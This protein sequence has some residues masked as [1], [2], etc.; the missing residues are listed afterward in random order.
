MSDI[1]RD[2][3]TPHYRWAVSG[4]PKSQFITIV[5][6]DPTQGTHENPLAVDVCRIAIPR[7]IANDIAMAM[8]FNEMLSDDSEIA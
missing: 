8:I 5:C 6:M 7:E 1:I 4:L 2:P 3:R